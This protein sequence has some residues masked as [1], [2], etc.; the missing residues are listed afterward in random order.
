MYGADPNGGSKRNPADSKEDRW[1][2]FHISEVK[3]RNYKIDSLK[4][5]KDDSLDDADSLPE[6]EELAVEA[7]EELRLAMDELQKI[8]VLLENGDAAAVEGKK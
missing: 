2:S 3:E 7:I 8:V 4:W 6:P 5:L 1:H